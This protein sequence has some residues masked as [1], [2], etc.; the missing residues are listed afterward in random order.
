M[1]SQQIETLDPIKTVALLHVGDYSGVFGAF[2]R[3]GAWAGANNL[4]E[5]GPRMAGIYHDDPTNTPVEQLRS[6]ACLE[7]LSPVTLLEGMEHYTISGG[8][9]FVATM[10]LKMDEFGEAWQRIYVEVAKQ[11]YECD[12]RDHYELY[13]NCVD[14]AQ[15][16]DAPWVAKICI[17]VK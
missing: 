2:E 1:I 5:K 13:I 11:G 12:Q 16:E 15:G 14:S 8:K 17:P 4:W 7:D 10:E 6:H 9:Y 3:L